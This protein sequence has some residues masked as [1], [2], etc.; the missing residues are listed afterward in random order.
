[1]RTGLESRTGMI[2]GVLIVAMVILISAAVYRVGAANLASPPA[3][4]SL[5]LNPY[6]FQGETRTAYEVAQKH[7]ELLAQLDCY[8]GCEQHEGHK[9]L[10]D[11]FRTNHGAGCNTC[12]GEAVTAGKLA[13][14]GMPVEQIREALRTQYAHAS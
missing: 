14:G 9:N 4:E 11:C 12:T 7:P 8:C 13:D 5:T 3:S 1:M 6:Q 10:L 2:V